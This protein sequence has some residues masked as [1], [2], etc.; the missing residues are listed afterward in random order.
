MIQREITEPQ[1]VP[2][3]AKGHRARYMLDMRRHCEGAA[4]FL[5]CRTVVN[6]SMPRMSKR[7]GWRHA[8]LRPR[9][10][11]LPGRQSG[12]LCESSPCFIRAR[13]ASTTARCFAVD[14]SDPVTLIRTAIMEGRK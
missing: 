6:L 3:C 2:R 10:G 9:Q 13:L 14:D 7:A 11:C 1:P 4:L 8:W 12:L 5:D